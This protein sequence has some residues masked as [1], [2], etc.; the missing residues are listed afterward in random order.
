MLRGAVLRSGCVLYR[1]RDDHDL[2]CVLTSVGILSFYSFIAM[3]V[4]EALFDG[5]HCV[6]FEMALAFGLQ[7]TLVGSLC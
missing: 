7:L 5:F 3:A 6:Y 4:V 2:T 1:C